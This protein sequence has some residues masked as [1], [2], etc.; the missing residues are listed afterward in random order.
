MA[1]IL[2]ARIAE[3]VSKRVLPETQC[4]FREERSSVDM[5]FLVR[6]IQEKCREKHGEF[7]TV[8]VDMQKAFDTVQSRSGLGDY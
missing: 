2:F 8:F 3:K 7:H 4:G 6:Q 1:N 5:L